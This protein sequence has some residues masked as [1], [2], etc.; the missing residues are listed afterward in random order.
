MIFSFLFNNPKFLIILL[1]LFYIISLLVIK[2]KRARYVKPFLSNT[3]KFKLDFFKYM[4]KYYVSNIFYTFFAVILYFFGHSGW[5]L[6]Y[7]I[8]IRFNKDPKNNIFPI[9]YDYTKFDFYMI[10]NLIVSSILLLTVFIMF[11]VMLDRLF[12]DEVLKLHLFLLKYPFYNII[13]HFMTE[14]YIRDFFGKSY[15]YFY[16]VSVL[17]ED[18][19]DMSHEIEAFSYKE[20][21]EKTYIRKT[22]I[23]L[24]KLFKKYSIV[25]MFIN[26]LLALFQCLYN[27]IRLIL[28]AQYIPYIFL[29]IIIFYGFIY[30]DNLYISYLFFIIYI[31][32]QLFNYSKFITKRDF[33]YDDLI[34]RYFYKN[35][36]NYN[37]QRVW[38]SKDIYLFLD[39]IYMSNFG[40]T[41]LFYMEDA[42]YKSGFVNYVLYDCISS[43]HKEFGQQDSV[44]KLLNTYKRYYILSLLLLGTYYVI[45]NKHKYII[46]VQG[47]N[48]DISILC[49]IVPIISIIVYSGI[50]IFKSP[51]S[52]IHNFT[53]EYIYKKHY[54]IIFWSFTIIH[55]YCVWLLIFKANIF[56]ISDGILWDKWG[57]TLVRNYTFEE[58][59]LYFY[60]HLHLILNEISKQN[61]FPYIINQISFLIEELSWKDLITERTTIAQT[62]ELV[63]VFIE[64]YFYHVTLV[65]E[66]YIHKHIL[67]RSIM[68]CISNITNLIVFCKFTDL[69]IKAWYI[70]THPHSSA[71]IKFVQRLLS[72]LLRP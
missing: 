33:V 17:Q 48:I 44:K 66:S 2:Y 29:V 16:N 35:D 45:S 26:L 60:D 38:L 69:Y 42:E 8:F 36:L 71:A 50:N 37:K 70:V 55:L 27:H 30:P 53:D 49:L 14:S 40:K 3:V 39:K 41:I 67:I 22:S 7:N 13:T 15:L 18:Y 28:F 10:S 20:I 1:L 64:R 9:N 5:I 54:N 59:Y 12:Y 25:R 31:I 19:N 24:I 58:K 57:I 34:T 46:L 4:D 43:Y 11:K 72:D 68:D 23:I 61:D 47:S 52:N 63:E 6:V 65:Q 62:K 32:I 56:L 51:K 21:Y